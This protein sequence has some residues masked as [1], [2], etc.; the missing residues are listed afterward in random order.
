V[1]ISIVISSLLKVEHVQLYAPYAQA[2]GLSRTFLNVFKRCGWLG[3]A[4]A[5]PGLPDDV[6]LAVGGNPFSLTGGC[7]AV[8]VRTKHRPG[9]MRLRAAS[10]A[11]RARSRVQNQSGRGGAAFDL[12][13]GT[14]AFNLTLRLRGTP[15]REEHEQST[16]R[17]SLL[18]LLR[19][20]LLPEGRSGDGLSR[21][22]CVDS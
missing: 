7:G 18:L 4:P 5:K 11:G 12:T 17:Q 1:A 22:G 10:N 20:A 9:A 8:W 14:L 2:P 13:L 15:A 16:Q 6:S 19:S 3:T 21:V